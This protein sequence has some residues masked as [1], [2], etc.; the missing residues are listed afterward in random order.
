LVIQSIRLLHYHHHLFLLI[1]VHQ[2][3]MDMVQ[4]YIL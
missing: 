1:I 3:P 2:N 4:Y